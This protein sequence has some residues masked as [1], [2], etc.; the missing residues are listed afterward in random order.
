M[1]KSNSALQSTSKHA[2]KTAVSPST[3][4]DKPVEH[5]TQT[6]GTAWGKKAVEANNRM[7]KDP[8]FA[9]EIAKKIF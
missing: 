1:S 3:P 7:K 5:P 6:A 9:A 2:K 4:T 8:K